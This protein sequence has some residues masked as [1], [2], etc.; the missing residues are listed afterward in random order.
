MRHLLTLYK[1]IY[2]H[3]IFVGKVKAYIGTYDYYISIKWKSVVNRNDN[4]YR[5]LLNN[6]KLIYTLNL[7][8]LMY[9]K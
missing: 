3:I 6:I 1:S 9:N 2:T 8:I 7:Y 4:K 5:I